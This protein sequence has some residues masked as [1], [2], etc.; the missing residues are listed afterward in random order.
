MPL[1]VPFPQLP[2]ELQG[3]QGNYLVAREEN[4]DLNHGY[5]SVIYKARAAATQELLALKTIWRLK[6]P[7]PEEDDNWKKA[8]RQ[9][10]NEITTLAKLK[11]I[12]GVVQVR[13]RG[14]YNDLPWY[15]MEYVKGPAITDGLRGKSLQEQVRTLRK[16]VKA[17]SQA[18]QKGIVHLD[19]KPSNILLN[20]F[21]EPVI[22]D[23]GISK[24]V[25]LAWESISMST[26]IFG[27]PRYMAP[28]QF[29]SEQKPNSDLHQIDIWAVGVLFYEILVN[30][31]PLGVD[32][33]DTY[34]QM[35]H[36][37]LYND[38]KDLS[39]FGKEVDRT[40]AEICYRALSKDKAHRYKNAAEMFQDLNQWEIA[41]FNKCIL[42][43]D[44]Y[45]Q[46]QHWQEAQKS[47]LEAH[48]W[49][50]Y[51]PK[52]K[53]SLTKALCGQCKLAV[54][55]EWVETV[56]QDMLSFWLK[57][58]KGNGPA[59]LAKIHYMNNEPP[60]FIAVD[61]AP[62]ISL[63]ELLE[64][65]EAKDG[66]AV[67]EPN[68]ALLLLTTLRETLIFAEHNNLRLQGLQPE[69]I[70]CVLTPAEKIKEFQLWGVGWRGKPSTDPLRDIRQLARNTLS[71]KSIALDPELDELFRKTTNLN[72]MIHGLDQFA[73]RQEADDLI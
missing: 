38:T 73:N 42:L 15:V 53:E 8:V 60:Y 44:E 25:E 41:N 5:M 20:E 26:G 61:V 55:I 21:Q 7:T 49:S 13:D 68:E 22:L 46:Y 67:L 31:H 51:H 11:D 57:T 48:H 14:E 35:I 27:T 24:V 28:E 64:N 1:Q 16:L 43:A 2:L 19:L 47:A 34:N 56:S 54:S 23:F 63:C 10:N 39:S 3:S 45:L 30:D 58:R 59:T 70:Y 65:R 17:L 29:A 9:F 72:E 66:A 4:R 6:E 62:G 52:I 32:D 50:P 71:D 12:P 33:G 37:I 18:H 40:L 69:N 36:K